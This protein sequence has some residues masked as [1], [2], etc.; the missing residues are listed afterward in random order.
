M[1][2]LLSSSFNSCVLDVL[3][4][5]PC[6]FHDP[7]MKISV[8]KIAGTKGVDN[9][10]GDDGLRLR[11]MRSELKNNSYSSFPQGWHSFLG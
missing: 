10:N 4:F 6:F 8:C 1:G 2:N 9:N 3:F 5:L 11:H 7:F